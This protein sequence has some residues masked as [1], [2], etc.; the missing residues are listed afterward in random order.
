MSEHAQHGIHPDPDV[1]SAFAEG[2]LAEHE[3]LVCL[4]HLAACPQCREI[5]W[6][7]QAAEAAEASPAHEPKPEPAPFWKRWLTPVPLLSTA[8]VAALA[9]TSVVIYRHQ[10]PAAPQ[11][12]LM[13]KVEAPPAS[14]A[15]PAE[16]KMAPRAALHPRT[17]HQKPGLAMK[18]SQAPEPVA[19]PSPLAQA[20]SSPVQ[21]AAPPPVPQSFL[22]ASAP[23]QLSGVTGTVTDPAGAAVPNAEV[24]FVASAGATT[25]RSATNSSGQFSVTG[26]PPGTYEMR[27]DSPGFNRARN[28]I[29]LQPAQIATADSVLKAGTASDTVAV[30]AEVAPAETASASARGGGGRGGRA[31]AALA[32]TSLAFKAALP[33][34]AN[35]QIML[36]ADAAGALLRSTDA[37]KSWKAVKG[38][39]QGKVI[40]LV[41]PPDAPGAGDA[42]F[43]LSTDTGDV[44]LSHDGN[45]WTSAPAH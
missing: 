45:N 23:N 24:Q 35:G 43:Q 30:T 8:A 21:P 16:K 33:S 11:P 12:E 6:L 39:W 17:A 22:P 32:A 38:N 19:P 42:V 5:V 15:A 2:A 4:D 20:A 3:R 41:A 29:H 7:T 28:E 18:T 34:A 40:R 14:V 10:K 44:W 27:V 25:V 1:L 26:I 36:R 9:V 13:A 31:K 37:G